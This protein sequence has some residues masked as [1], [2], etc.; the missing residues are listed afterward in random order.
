MTDHLIY[1]NLTAHSPGFA[2]DLS[3]ELTLLIPT[4][5]DTN[6]Q[7]QRAPATGCTRAGQQ[8]G[9]PLP[10]QKQL[11]GRVPRFSRETRQQVGKRDRKGN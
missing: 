4:A 3:P 10:T 6:S 8:Q 9:K 1:S 5:G 11:N 2:F 7:R